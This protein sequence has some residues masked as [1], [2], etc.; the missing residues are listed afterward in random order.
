MSNDIHRIVRTGQGMG[1]FLA[2]PG[3]PDHVYEVRSYYVRPG[4]ASV[5]IGARNRGNGA[6]GYASVSSVI[7]NEY[8]STRT[9]S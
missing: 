3:H 1:G 6:D 7:A 2:P 9:A 5:N 8:G 4:K